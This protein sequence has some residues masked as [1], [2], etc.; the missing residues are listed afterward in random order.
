[1]PSI[2]PSKAS[3]RSGRPA[4]QAKP[5]EEDAMVAVEA[6]VRYRDYFKKHH[7]ER[8]PDAEREVI[9]AIFDGAKN[10]TSSKK[11]AEKCRISA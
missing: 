8:L 10:K 11:T 2:D 9:K 5:T 3:K 4:A 6:G 7:L 1:V